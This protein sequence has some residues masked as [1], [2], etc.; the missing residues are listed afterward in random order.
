VERKVRNTPNT[1]IKINKTRKIKDMNGL[2]SIS[3]SIIS[4]R[5]WT[6]D[7]VHKIKDRMIKKEYF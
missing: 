4:R 2:F 6:I 7:L 1:G 3:S 5:K